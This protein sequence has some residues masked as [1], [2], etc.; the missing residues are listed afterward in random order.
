MA[1][2]LSCGRCG[3]LAARA[4]DRFCTA[5]GMPLG[6]MVAPM[7]RLAA[8]AIALGVAALVL[9]VVLVGAALGG[10]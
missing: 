9:T 5:C 10:R 8:G 1:T 7:R 2:R 4:T 3:K 6:W